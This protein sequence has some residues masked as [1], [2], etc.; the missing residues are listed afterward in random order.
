VQT[1]AVL[2]QNLSDPAY[3]FDLQVTAQS[4]LLAFVIGTAIGGGLDCS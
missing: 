2:V 4:V 3:L 1:A